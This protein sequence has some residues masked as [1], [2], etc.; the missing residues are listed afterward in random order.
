MLTEPLRP[1]RI[2]R[3]AILVE[4]RSRISSNNVRDVIRYL[5]GQGV[6]EPYFFGRAKHPH[7]QLTATG[8]KF[9]DL[10]IRAPHREW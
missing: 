6:V 3:K 5:K 9:R 1:A 4:P 8:Q 2:K 10:L 7:Y